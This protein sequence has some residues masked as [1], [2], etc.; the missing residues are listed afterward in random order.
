[1]SIIPNALINTVIMIIEFI[2]NASCFWFG[3]GL[4]VE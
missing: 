3:S 2:Q 4:I 1:M